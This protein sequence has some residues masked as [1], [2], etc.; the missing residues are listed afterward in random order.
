MALFLTLYKA[1]DFEEAKK[2]AILIQDYQGAGH[3]LSIHSTNRERI[4]SLA[5]EVK[6]A[7]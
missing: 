7:E 1:K 2:L 4:N 5:L 6:A 3:S